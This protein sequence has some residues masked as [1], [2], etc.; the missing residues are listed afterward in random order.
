MVA[1]MKP[2]LSWHKSNTR[3]QAKGAAPEEPARSMKFGRRREH[4]AQPASTSDTDRIA[5][6]D[7]DRRGARRCFEDVREEFRTAEH[8]DS[9]TRR[10]DELD[11]EFDQRGNRPAQAEI[12]ALKHSLT[13]LSRE[14]GRR[15]EREFFDVGEGSHRMG[16]SPAR[17][18]ASAEK[19]TPW[20]TARPFVRDELREVSSDHSRARV[21]S[22]GGFAE[23]QFGR[24]R[25]F[26]DRWRVSKATGR[27]NSTSRHFDDFDR[28]VACGKGSTTDAEIAAI[29]RSLADLSRDISRQMERGLNDAG[30]VGGLPGNR[31]RFEN[32]LEATSAARSLNWSTNH[33]DDDSREADR[34]ESRAPDAKAAGPGR[35]PQDLSETA[36]DQI[37]RTGGCRGRFGRRDRHVRDTACE[38]RLTPRAKRRDRRQNDVLE[39][40]AP[41]GQRT[42]STNQAHLRTRTS[43]GSLMMSATARVL[44]SIPVRIHPIRRTL[45]SQQ[46]RPRSRVLP[47]A[48][49]S[50][51]GLLVAAIVVVAGTYFTRWHFVEPYA[52]TLALPSLFHHNTPVAEAAAPQPT[53]ILP[54]YALARFQDLRFPLPEL[55]GVYAINR[56]KL[57]ELD[58]LPGQVPDH[59]IAMSAPV[60]QPSH[61]T[62]SDGHVAFVIFRRDVTDNISERVPIRVVAKIKRPISDPA[63]ESRSTD[64]W[65]I[66]NVALDFRVAPVDRN[67]DMVLLRPESPDFTFPAGRYALVIKGQAYDFTV[68]G[69]ITDPTQCLERV[70]AASG[71]FFHE[72]Q[73]E[74]TATGPLPQEAPPSPA[75]PLKSRRH[76]E[77]RANLPEQPAKPR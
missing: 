45:A 53:G 54:R 44:P 62:L 73:P 69:P 37:E 10:L 34:R 64:A 33:L 4:G 49:A 48:I 2:G 35:C 61:T 63:S 20:P 46:K 29:K 28:D 15:A 43:A 13:E 50:L 55:Y 1:G 38:A 30:L 18:A 23:D 24:L 57:F 66:R 59:R 60:S 65:T 40:T 56:G 12:A 67:K 27:L 52:G 14:I 5:N 68:D 70:E 3:S 72:C 31:R 74:A 26:E 41:V 16:I 7:C 25:R 36:L 39:T 21:E 42:E 8:L 71:S 22:V 51:A 17:R 11:R 75:L 32:P 19:A 76:A 58:T 9:I 6:L 47:L 77:A